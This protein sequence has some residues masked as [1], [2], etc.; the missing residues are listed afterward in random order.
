MLTRFV[1]SPGQVQQLLQAYAAPSFDDIRS[2]SLT[3]ETAPEVVR[4]L[5]PPPLEPAAEP[6]VSVSV[7]KVRRSNCVGPF[8]GAS[9]NIACTYRGEP[10]LYCLTMPMDTGIA[11]IFG[12]ELYAEPKKLADI[13]LEETGGQAR[14]IVTR[15]GVS[16][17]EIAGTFDAPL[18]PV[19]AAGTTRHYYFKYLPAAD[20]SG[21]AFD[22]ELVCVTHTGRTHNVTRGT[23]TVTFRES[24]HD[25]LIDIPV[26]SVGPATLSEGETKTRAEVVA[27]V[28]AA[29]FL[30]Y[31]FAKTDDLTRWAYAPQP[32]G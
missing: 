18:E 8:N 20:G 23:G 16:F 24:V 22:P 10:G 11:V 6:R 27:T 13:R 19:D 30:P 4:E 2:L 1:K 26:L 25:P 3:F 29:D 14:G 31:A 21:L 32:V 5:I 12:R 9:V 7:Y 17:L 15:H 28:P